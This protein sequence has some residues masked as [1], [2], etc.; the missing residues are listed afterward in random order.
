LA[1]AEALQQCRGAATVHEKKKEVGKKKKEKTGFQVRK[2]Q[3]TKI[4]WKGL[5]AYRIKFRV[6]DTKHETRS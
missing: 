3:E 6:P 5:N 4:W 2:A 1:R